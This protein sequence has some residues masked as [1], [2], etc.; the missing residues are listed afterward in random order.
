MCNMFSSA[1]SK[2][3]SLRIM[4]YLKRNVKMSVRGAHREL[5]K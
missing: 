1:V 3:S 2:I 4:E 5:L